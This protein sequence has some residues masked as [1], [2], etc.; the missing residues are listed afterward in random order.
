MR[1]F[2]LLF[3]PVNWYPIRWLLLY[4]QI[5]LPSIVISL[6]FQPVGSAYNDSLSSVGIMDAESIASATPTRLYLSNSDSVCHP[7]SSKLKSSS[8]KVDLPSF[9]STV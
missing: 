7:P 4:S 1:F 8:V 9:I 2:Q 6:F 5:C 3:S